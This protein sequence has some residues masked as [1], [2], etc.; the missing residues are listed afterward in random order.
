M[1]GFA[2][3]GA[4]RTESE[5][6][7]RLPELDRR[8]VIAQAI[9]AKMGA[10]V[11][12]GNPLART[13]S[14][15]TADELSSILAGKFTSSH[16]LADAKRPLPSPRKDLDAAD[17]QL[18]DELYDKAE[19]DNRRAFRAANA[20]TSKALIST[21]E[22]AVQ[23]L[24]KTPPPAEHDAIVKRF[25]LSDFRPSQIE[26]IEPSDLH[27]NVGEGGDVS[28]THTEMTL[29]GQTGQLATVRGF[30]GFTRVDVI[31]ARWGLLGEL[32]RELIQAARR[33]ERDSIVEMLERNP[34]LSDGLPLFA[35]TRGNDVSTG[36]GV[37]VSVSAANAALRGITSAHGSALQP[38]A[39]VLCVPAAIELDLELLELAARAKLG[40][41]SDSRLTYGY[42]LPPPAERPVV[43]LGTLDGTEKPWTLRLRPHPSADAWRLQIVSD[44]TVKPL[45]WHAVRFTF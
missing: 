27:A 25:P 6:V 39:G 26:Q 45:S 19:R 3:V 34:V 15:A 21:V 41:F 2:Y 9:A 30:V 23:M 7:A 22:S 17:R 28:I 31:N 38:R 32:T 13:L 37:A 33:A 40:V 8:E 24:A 10:H 43:G 11:H 29:S 44:F 5:L 1:T 12:E 14:E 4:M 36:P 16:E 20:F 42:L 18:F 35:E